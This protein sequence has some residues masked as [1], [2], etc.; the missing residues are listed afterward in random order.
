MS[1][2]SH[3]PIERILS[4][5]TTLGG[6]EPGSIC[7]EEVLHI[8]QISKAGASLSDCSVSYPGHSLGGWGVLPLGKDALGLFCRAPPPASQLGQLAFK[9]D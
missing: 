8:P 9:S 2:S 3:W 5:A 6:I 1:N 7:N 4:D